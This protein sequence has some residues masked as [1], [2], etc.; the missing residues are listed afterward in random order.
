MSTQMDHKQD[1]ELLAYWEA[2]PL[3]PLVDE[4]TTSIVNK[5]LFANFCPE[6]SFDR[7]GLFASY[8]ARYA[9]EIDRELAEQWLAR[10]GAS[11][12]S[13]AWNWQTVQEMHYTDCP[14]Y[15]QLPLKGSPPTAVKPGDVLTIKPALWGISIDIKQLIALGIRWWRKRAGKDH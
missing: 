12:K 13:W 11:P 2:T 3:W 7:F 14:L 10:N 5:S 4:H 1:K 15:A 9:D 8:L 6:V